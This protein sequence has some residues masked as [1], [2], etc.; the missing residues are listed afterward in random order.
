MDLTAAKHCWSCRNHRQSQQMKSI[1]IKLLSEQQ[2]DDSLHVVIIFQIVEVLLYAFLQLR[3]FL[4]VPVL[5]DGEVECQN[6]ASNR[7]LGIHF[8]LCI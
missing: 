3:H 1:L 5:E 4:R 8:I 7:Y 6:A 2:V